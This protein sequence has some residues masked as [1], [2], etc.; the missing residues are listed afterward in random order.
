MPAFALDPHDGHRQH[1]NA[2]E[3]EETTVMRDLLGDGQRRF[4][5]G[6]LQAET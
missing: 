3:S 2:L 5:R 1:P 4:H 6:T